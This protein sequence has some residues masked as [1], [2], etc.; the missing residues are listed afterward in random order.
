MSSFSS[1]QML[2]EWVYAVKQD[3]QSADGTPAVYAPGAPMYWDSERAKIAP[4][5]GI[6][7][8]AVALNSNA[9]LLAVAVEN[10]VYVYNTDKLNL[11]QVLKGH[12]SAVSAVTFHSQ[13]S[14][15]LVSCSMDRYKDSVPQEPDIIVWDLKDSHHQDRL[16]SDA[17]IRTLAGRA[18]SSISAGLEDSDSKWKLN[19]DEKETLLQELQKTIGTLNVKYAS[20]ALLHLSGRLT[21][22]LQSETFSHDGESLIYLPGQSPR[23]N[24]DV[25]WD[26][27]VWNTIK[28][29]LRLTLKG[30]TDSIM[31]TG[32]SP[33]DK[34][35]ATV[36]WDKTNRLWDAE[37]GKL[38]H[39]FTTTGQNWTGAFSPDSKYFASTC[40]V[41]DVF[42][43]DVASGEEIA[44]YKFGSWCRAIDWSP[45]G[46]H[47]AMSGKNL[48]KIVVFDV[49][50]QTVVQER[51]LST[52]KCPKEH[53]DFIPN[54]LEVQ[55]LKYLPGG[56]KIAYH[57][58]GDDGVEVYD[59]VD[60][61]KWRFAPPQG[62][63]RAHG[64]GFVFLPRQG[65][66]VSG[67][68][69]ALRVWDLPPSE[70]DDWN[71]TGGMV[72]DVL[73]PLR[74]WVVMH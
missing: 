12:V 62:K 60:N 68:E 15:R 24:S 50:S 52:E 29:E 32:F 64:W 73:E 46:Q 16:E 20:Q 51:L 54:F 13:I 3:F 58:T 18:L 69:D 49:Q 41:G 36:S 31:W 65:A 14:H 2:K 26:I 59:F 71:A 27:C 42:I 10:E 8:K 23:S 5:G 39:T 37:S 38:V 55:T 66:I 19:A 28:K 34:L 56:R 11:Q 70:G 53:R 6:Q 47:L 63:I 17:A 61:R 33:D 7:F 22:H 48:G 35:I 25:P 1:D 57:T 4:K 67:A 9:T 72:E 45:D 40:G 21:T 74:D 43:W 44:S 30:H